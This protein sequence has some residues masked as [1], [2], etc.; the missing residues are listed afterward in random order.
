MAYGSININR[1]T[2]AKRIFFLASAKARI[3]PKLK[4]K[5][6]AQIAQINVQRA[7][8]RNVSDHI[9]KFKQHNE[10]FNPNPINPGSLVGCDLAQH[11]L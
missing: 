4:V 7:T 6:V 1:Q 9:C 10:I 2:F 11:S 3:K 5:I 8:P